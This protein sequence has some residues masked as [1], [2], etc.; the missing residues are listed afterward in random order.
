MKSLQSGIRVRDAHTD[1]YKAR[2]KQVLRAEWKAGGGRK[3]KKVFFEKQMQKT[4]P[5]LD[6]QPRGGNKAVNRQA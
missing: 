1:N 3:I 2:W 6:R 5:A 4:E